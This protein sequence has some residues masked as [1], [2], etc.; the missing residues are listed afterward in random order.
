MRQFLAG[1]IMGAALVGG[2]ATARDKD[3][4]V[5]PDWT[6]GDGTRQ[7]CKGIVVNHTI[8][9]VSCRYRSAAP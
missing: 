8:K 1:V 2:A 6:L 9:N 4:Q 5:W 7:L 3:A